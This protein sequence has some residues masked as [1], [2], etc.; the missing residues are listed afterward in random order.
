MNTPGEKFSGYIIAKEGYRPFI[1]SGEVLKKL[2]KRGRLRADDLV[3]CDFQK[4]WK[5]A[6]HVKGLRT[7]FARKNPKFNES[8]NQQDA[9]DY[10]V[11]AAIEQENLSSLQMVSAQ[12]LQTN[13]NLNFSNQD[14]HHFMEDESLR[15]A[16]EYLKNGAPS[17]DN[18]VSDTWSG[19]FKPLYIIGFIAILVLGSIGYYFFLANKS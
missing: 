5:K 16:V 14:I 17:D 2:A 11:I 10:D 12:S 15:D 13:A 9:N 6:R 3:F 8:S 1:V 4:V 18:F 19:V 7:F